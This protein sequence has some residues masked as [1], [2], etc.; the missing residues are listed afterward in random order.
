MGLKTTRLDDP[1][2]LARASIAGWMGVVSTSPAIAVGTI[3]C[4]SRRRCTVVSAP[5]DPAV[6]ACN[7]PGRKRAPDA[8]LGGVNGH[9]EYIRRRVAQRQGRCREHRGR[10]EQS[11][12]LGMSR[13]VHSPFAGRRESVTGRRGGPLIEINGRSSL[14]IASIAP[15]AHPAFHNA[16]VPVFC[17]TGQLIFRIPARAV[18][19]MEF[20]AIWETLHLSATPAALVP[21]YCRMVSCPHVSH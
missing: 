13:H 10:Y 6:D 3:G 20:G 1:T 5:M 16:I 8:G 17:P 18:S 2:S 14:G 11:Y 12:Q 21:G 4:S 19:W 15:W 7:A 9:G